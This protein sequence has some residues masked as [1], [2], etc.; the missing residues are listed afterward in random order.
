MLAQPTLSIC[1]PSRN[2]QRYFQETIRSL[3][4][5]LR[6]DVEFVFADNSDDPAP[7]RDFMVDVI[8]DPRV[9]FIPP[10]DRVYS[11]VDNWERC[12]EAATGEF[13]CIIGDDDF[14]DAD[15]IDLINSTKAERGSVDVF[16]WSRFTYNWP[17]NRRN[18]CNVCIPLNTGV[19]EIKREWLYE[20]FLPGSSTAPRRIARLR[21]ITAP[22]PRRS[23]TRSS[24]SSATAI[25][26][27]RRWIS[28][29]AASF[30]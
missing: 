12:V 24:L 14:M 20:E 18:K 29:T 3:L 9:K 8:G 23:W 1:V 22:S 28:K 27:I 7:M 6:T 19:H 21:S 17:G 13:V 10:G 2:R 11:M 4:V 16:V 30:W 25:S 26:S 5:N 15:V